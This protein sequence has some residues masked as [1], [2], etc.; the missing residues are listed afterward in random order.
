MLIHRAGASHEGR[1]SGLFLSEKLPA[2][3]PGRTDAAQFPLLAQGSKMLFHSPGR[4]VECFGHLP[5]R[6]LW[7]GTEQ[8][9]DFFRTGRQ[10]FRTY[11]FSHMPAETG[12]TLLRRAAKILALFQNHVV[13]PFHPANPAGKRD[14]MCTGP[15]RLRFQEK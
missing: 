9:E 3:T 12:K 2:A 7:I 6:E 13:K 4:D 5:G 14:W 1:G 8:S 10:T 11:P 15:Q